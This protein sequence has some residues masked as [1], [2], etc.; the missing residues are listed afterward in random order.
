MHGETDI[1]ACSSVDFRRRDS[2]FSK[3]DPSS[4]PETLMHRKGDLDLTWKDAFVY[5]GF[6]AGLL[7]PTEQQ[8]Q[9]FDAAA[10]IT[11]RHHSPSSGGSGSVICS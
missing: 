6:R 9:D 8:W 10:I 1:H 11:K 4:F 3:V 2:F 5:S 7:I